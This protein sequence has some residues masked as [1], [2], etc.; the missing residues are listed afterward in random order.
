[1]KEFFTKK[2]RKKSNKLNNMGLFGDLLKSGMSATADGLTGGLASGIS[3]AVSGLFGG[4]G[5]GKRARR[6]L[7]MQKE[8]N[9][10]AARLNYEYGEKAAENAYQRQMQM[11]ERSYQ[12]QSYSAMRQ[13][14]ENAGLSVGLMYGGGGSGGAGGATTGAPQGE[15]GGAE[16]GRADS[17][18]AQQAAA[19]QQ[20]QLGLGLV[21]MKKDLALKD[22][23]IEEIN[24]TAEAK[25]AEA[26]LTTEKKVT[27]MQ[28]REKFLK[29]L[30]EENLKTWLENQITIFKTK[31]NDDNFSGFISTGPDGNNYE[32]SKNSFLG[33]ELAAEIAKKWAEAG[34]A[35]GNEESARAMAKLNNEKTEGYWME[36]LN[37]SIHADAHA[38]EAAARKLAAEHET[39]EYAN[40]KTWVDIGADITSEIA[41]ILLFRK[42]GGKTGIKK[43]KPGSR[44]LVNK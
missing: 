3:G 4:I 40:W 39:G 8:L 32:F 12:D 22:A 14:M 20:A 17:P 27:E 36:L 6:Q 21:S 16:A 15:T 24:A 28:Q 26:G 13:Q 1:M 41:K 37:A 44:G 18:A 43:I 5:A 23:Q 19:I 34:E 38:M 10:Q 2:S 30:D 7:K 33:E 42:F 25:R 31:F 11:Y 9:E 35:S 29:K